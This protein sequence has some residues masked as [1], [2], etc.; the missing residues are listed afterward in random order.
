MIAASCRSAIT[1][2]RLT[3]AA[4]L[5]AV[6]SVPGPL[7]GQDAN[8][9]AVGTGAGAQDRDGSRSGHRP[10]LV[11]ADDLTRR[12]IAVLRFEGR[13]VAGSEGD[14]AAAT[15]EDLATDAGAEGRVVEQLV[16]ALGTPWTRFTLRHDPRETPGGIR[17]SRLW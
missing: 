2:A 15:P 1:R 10:M 3:A 7:V 11:I 9:W 6:V 12:G 17:Q 13:G 14:F 8:D 16:G 4:F 5:A